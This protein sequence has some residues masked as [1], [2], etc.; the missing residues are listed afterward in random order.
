MEVIYKDTKKTSPKVNEFEI[1]NKVFVYLRSFNR[2]IPKQRHNLYNRMFNK[3]LTQQPQ[4]NASLKRFCQ[5]FTQP[6]F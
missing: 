3:N 4:S 2:F 6:D 1:N 5:N